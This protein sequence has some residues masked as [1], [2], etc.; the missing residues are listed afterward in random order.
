M[1]KSVIYLTVI[2][3]CLLLANACGNSPSEPTPAAPLTEAEPVNEDDLLARL[4]I[5]LVPNPGTQGEMDQ[6]AIINYAIDNLLDVQRSQTGLYYQIVEPGEGEKIRWGQKTTAHYIGELLNGKTFDSSKDRGV[7]LVFT[8]GNM[9]QGWNE[10]VQLLRPGG[11]AT[12]LIP[13][14]LGYKDKGFITSQGDTLIPP[15]EPL[16]FDIEVLKKE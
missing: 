1:N 8:V 13:S 12:L 4:S 14:H 11:K 15:N 16:R 3:G 9:V 2:A 5:E 6:N 7:P 10:G